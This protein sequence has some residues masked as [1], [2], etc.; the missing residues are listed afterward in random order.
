MQHPERHSQAVMQDIYR[1][2][3][4]CGSCHK[5]NLP[6]PLNEY[7]WIRAFTAYDEWQN[8]KF[9]KRNPLTFY[10]ADYATCQSCHM[11]REVA[12]SDEYGAKKGT[13]ASHRWLA[14]NTAVPFYYGFG[15]QL[16]KTEA[17]LK[18]GKY[19]NVDL[20]GI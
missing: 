6:V 1:Q 3:E 10:S 2:P 13:F 15:E 20:F 19:L 4:F 5:A 16:Q 11:R 12:Q 7:K 8:S 17:F 9:S 14:G 18:S